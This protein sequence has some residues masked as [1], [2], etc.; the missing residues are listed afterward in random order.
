MNIIWIGFEFCVDLVWVWC[1]SGMERWI[2][3]IYGV[4]CGVDHV[5]TRFGSGGDM[6]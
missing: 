6:M 5:W 1:G 3:C 4:D 2:R